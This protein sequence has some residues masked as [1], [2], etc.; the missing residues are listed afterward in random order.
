MDPRKNVTE[1]RYD[2]MNRIVNEIDALNGVKEF[3]YDASGNIISVKNENNN[4]TT[5]EYDSLNRVTVAIDP[6]N[7]RTRYTYNYLGLTVKAT[8]ALDNVVTIEY[9]EFGRQ[10]RII[11][12]TGGVKSYRYDKNSRLTSETDELGR[13][14]T[15]AY[16][17]R[18]RRTAAANNLNETV[19][20][21]YDA[22]GN[23]ITQI[24]AKNIEYRYEYDAISR[25]VREI[26]QKENEQSYRYD[27]NGNLVS[28]TD[29]NGATTNFIYDPLNRLKEA[30]FTDT[31]K[32]EFDYD[33]NGNMTR[34]ENNA[35]AIEFEYDPLNRLSKE[36]D[37]GVDQVVKYAYDN[38]GNRIETLWLN[39]QRKIRYVYGK[40]NE[41]LKVIDPEAGTTEY[42][43]DRLAREIMKK[44]S[45]G[46]TTETTY[47]PAGRVTMIRNYEDKVHGQ[48][49][50]LESYAYLYNAAGERINQIDEKGNIT[51]Y[52]Y[53]ELGRIKN[54][55][56]PFNENKKTEDFRERLYLG[57]YPDYE[58]GK[59]GGDICDFAF[60]DHPGYKRNEIEDSIRGILDNH[61]ALYK[62]YKNIDKRSFGRWK[63]KPV[64]GAT[65]FIKK[66]DF[67][68]KIVSELEA[69]LQK[70]NPKIRHGNTDSEFVWTESFAYDANNNRAS[71]ANG[72]GAIEYAYDSANELLNAGDRQYAYDANGNLTKESLGKLEAVYSYNPENRVID[73]YT[74]IEGFLCRDKRN[75]TNGVS[76]DYDALGRRSFSADYKIVTSKNK[77]WSNETNQSY[78]HDGLS[79]NILAEFYDTDFQGHDR[80]NHFGDWKYAY[81]RHNPV[82]EYIYG[83]GSVIERTDFRKNK[84]WIG[85][86]HLK[87]QD[88]TW[89]SQDILG[90]TILLTDAHGHSKQT[91]N[92]D[93]FGNNYSGEFERRNELGYN[94]KLF[95]PAVRL[96]DYGFRDYAPVVG[97]FTTVDPI[98]DGSNWYAYCGNDPVNRVD[99]WGLHPNSMEEAQRI[100]ALYSINPADNSKGILYKFGSGTNKNAIVIIGGMHPNEERGI[101][102]ADLLI[103]DIL[104]G[105]YK[106]PEGVD[107]YI[108]SKLSPGEIRG[109]PNPNRHWTKGDNTLPQIVRMG[110][111]IDLIYAEHLAEP[112]IIGLHNCLSKDAEMV[113]PAY[114]IYSPAQNVEIQ[115]PQLKS[116]TLARE[117][118][119]YFGLTEGPWT[120]ESV[121]DMKGELSWVAPLRWPGSAQFDIETYY[122]PLDPESK[123]NLLKNA[124][125]DKDA[126]E[127]FITDYGYSMSQKYNRGTFKSFPAFCLGIK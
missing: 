79:M 9:D 83:N 72:W 62:S 25:V 86:G 106:I 99:L 13:I 119:G 74:E 16:D 34:A 46:I 8:D 32:K 41:L 54:V 39:D 122:N 64:D 113:T 103:D 20:F 98:K 97:R 12:Q 3:G 45:N 76:Y 30:I 68:G 123:Q 124:S 40:L 38:A 57:L 44:T 80:G 49:N 114:N 93:V 100:S 84:S 69:A 6:Y 52:Q 109:N 23:L 26:N 35:K 65:D 89:Y 53:D 50:Y 63:I 7:Q 118:A 11:D 28:K 77:Q 61:S 116:Q 108:I 71:K 58:R 85:H 21:E 55:Y 2:K 120:A 5:M 66:L 27:G 126:I 81:P 73:I 91:Y 1:Y 33:A 17:S 60:P 104:S 121:Q 4:T 56:Y 78:L 117:M 48:D 95:D 96:Y 37:H 14:N 111:M 82:S 43:Y 24:D 125:E 112:V 18:N 75:I 105:E 87:D 92:Y 110:D 36:I 29:F 59:Y 94:G 47:D 88:K 10:V 102:A 90:S 15:Y 22:V 127:K 115:I 107:V 67:D 51:T 70:L 42:R 19:R 31:T 101:K